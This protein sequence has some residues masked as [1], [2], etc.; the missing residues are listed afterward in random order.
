MEEQ[1]LLLNTEPFFLLLPLSLDLSAFLKIHL[2]FSLFLSH[3][4]SSRVISPALSLYSLILPFYLSAL[5]PLLDSF[6]YHLIFSLYIP[7]GYLISL[8]SLCVPLSLFPASP[9][10]VLS[11]FPTFCISHHPLVLFLG[12]SLPLHVPFYLYLALLPSSSDI[13]LFLSFGS[14][15]SSSTL[16]IAPFFYLSEVVLIF[17]LPH[18]SLLLKI[19]AIH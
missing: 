17:P 9:S 11:P 13:C 4:H 5:V 16:L 19:I 15:F 3:H 12:I 18:Y 7:L 8:L 10:F 2:S 14:S 6:L 1:D